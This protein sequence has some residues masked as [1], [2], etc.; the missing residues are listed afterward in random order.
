MHWMHCIRLYKP[1]P[2]PQAMLGEGYNK[3]VSI[4]LIHLWD[5]VLECIRGIQL[6]SVPRKCIMEVYRWTV[7]CLTVRFINA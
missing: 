1:R 7:L 4:Y 2:Y 6:E 3:L 5:I